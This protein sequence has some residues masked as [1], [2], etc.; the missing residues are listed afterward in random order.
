MRIVSILL[1]IFFFWNTVCAKRA[2]ALEGDKILSQEI[3]CK[4]N[5]VYTILYDYNLNGDTIAVPDNCT[6]RFKGGSISNGYLFGS[7]FRIEGD[8]RLLN[9]EILSGC[10]K[11]DGCS[12]IEKNA[13]KTKD[14]SHQFQL[15]IKSISNCKAKGFFS[16]DRNIGIASRVYL[17]SN[18]TIDFTNAIIYKQNRYATIRS[19]GMCTKTYDTENVNI[20]NICFINENDYRHDCFELVGIKNLTIDGLSY[21]DF[22][23]TAIDVNGNRTSAW[24]VRVSGI[25]I[26]LKNITIDN[27][28]GGAWTDGVHLERCVNAEICDFNIKSGDDCIAIHDQL[29]STKWIGGYIPEV[30]K[31]IYVHDGVCQSNMAN[32]IRLGCEADSPSTFSLDSITIRNVV[33]N[34]GER[35]TF[36]EIR[37]YRTCSHPIYHKNIKIEDVS[38]V[39]TKDAYNMLH[40]TRTSFGWFDVSFSKLRLISKGTDSALLYIDGANSVSFNDCFIEEGSND[41]RNNTRIGFVRAPKM[42]IENSN[43]FLSAGNTLQV[44][45]I[46][47]RNNK[48]H[49]KA[50]RQSAF[51]LNS[52]KKTEF[53]NNIIEINSN[54][55]LWSTNTEK[56]AGDI[57]IKDNVI[58]DTSNTSKYL[59]GGS[60]SA[61]KYSKLVISGNIFKGNNR[62][63][64][65]SNLKFLSDRIIGWP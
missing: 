20:K 48:M 10:I 49:L 8:S 13:S 57:V 30:T 43:L 7:N 33:G 31:N 22:A 36:A 47:I 9:V 53:E 34:P 56:E 27:Y 45:T 42:I 55:V 2:D 26:L 37:D 19:Y 60:E 41:E 24:A 40:I 58:K 65:Q 15:F 35:N 21:K 1:Y 29:G 4:K 12:F 6:L 14:N 39:C 44:D 3:M 11:I 62:A 54:S 28:L 52:N 63:L 38:C 16:S 59:I 32:I 23:T 46:L 5:A 61:K 18:I 64:S 51:L 25:N 17:H 50:L